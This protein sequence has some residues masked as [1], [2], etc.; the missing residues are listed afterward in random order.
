MALVVIM[1]LEKE[2]E[3]VAK[4][5]HL[6]LSQE[7]RKRFA[8]ELG[9]VLRLFDELDKFDTSTRQEQIPSARLRDS[10]VRKTKAASLFKGPK[11]LE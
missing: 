9:E 2:L 5:A 7:E 10:V 8:G 4:L 6:R 11:V 3:I 1:D